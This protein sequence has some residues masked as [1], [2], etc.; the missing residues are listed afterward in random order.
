LK[1]KALIG[2][3]IALVFFVVLVMRL[4]AQWIAGF[5]PRDLACE[6][7]SGTIWN[8]ECGTLRLHAA[9]FGT[10]GWSLAPLRLLSGKL[11]ADVVLSRPPAR[12][13][14]NLELSPSGP[15]V[16]RAIIAD[17]PIEPAL[18]PELPENIAGRAHA[19]I[20]LL[21]LR[22]GVVESLEGSIQVHDL[23][24]GGADAAALGDYS[25]EFAHREAPGE[26]VGQLRDL[27]GPLSVEAT[28]RLTREPGF[29]LDGVIAARASAPPQLA[30][31]IET[32]GLPDSSGRRPF[33]IAGTF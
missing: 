16:A 6:E 32:L 3:A 30:E 27:G 2:V 14:G 31:D 25:L 15:I 11:V 24:Q 12:A 18:I 1:A 33:S 28:L 23:A 9:S 21:K 4:P 17:F 22:D 26:P 19:E 10:L 29:V 20:G 7:P 13:H 5:L 8:G